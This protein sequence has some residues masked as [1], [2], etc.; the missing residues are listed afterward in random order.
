[1]LLNGFTVT[2]CSFR[3]LLKNCAP[4]TRHNWTSVVQKRVFHLLE[5]EKFVHHEKSRRKTSTMRR[6]FEESRDWKSI[7]YFFLSSSSFSFPFVVPNLKIFLRFFLPPG[8][9]HNKQHQ[10]TRFSFFLSVGK[11]RMKRK[12]R[13]KSFENLFYRSSYSFVVSAGCEITAYDRRRRRRVK[14]KFSFR[15]RNDEC[16]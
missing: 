3:S 2:H 4:K 5:T 7:N 16:L 11:A 10:Q 15:L 9:S 1:M 6:S 14:K 8:W 13:P 12:S